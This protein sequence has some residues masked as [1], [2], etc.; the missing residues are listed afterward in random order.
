MSLA[1]VNVCIVSK[2][3]RNTVRNTPSVLFHMCL[4]QS[5]QKYKCYKL[6]V[7]QR[8]CINTYRVTKC[9]GYLSRSAESCRYWA[10]LSKSYDLQN[11]SA[12][13]GQMSCCVLY[14]FNIC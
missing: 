13:V 9:V 4:C 7:L 14:E 5:G 10:S 2:S 3:I 1:L 12:Q 8:P 6:S 11:R